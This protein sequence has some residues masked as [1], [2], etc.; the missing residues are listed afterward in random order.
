MPPPL[1]LSLLAANGQPHPKGEPLDRT[2]LWIAM[3]RLRA[4]PPVALLLLLTLLTGLLSVRQARAQ[5]GVA[6]AGEPQGQPPAVR[7]LSIR[8]RS[9]VVGASG[10]LSFEP[11]PSGGLVRLTAL[12]LPSLRMLFPGA[13]GYFVW[14]VP[15]KGAPIRVGELQIDASG[16][17]GVEFPR[18]EP[19]ERYSVIVTAELSKAAEKPKGMV[20]FSTW[21]GEAKAFFGPRNKTPAN[22]NRAFKEIRKRGQLRSAGSDFFAEVDEAL[23]LSLGRGRVIELFG[24]D[25]SPEAYGVA[26]VTALNSKAYIRAGFTKLPPPQ[27]IGANTYVLWAIKQSGQ[28]RYMGSLPT[29]EELDDSD[30]FVRVGGFNTNDY[31][32]FVTAE[33]LR[34]ASSPTGPRA[35]SSGQ[36]VTEPN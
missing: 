5:S 6:T 7:P 35:L 26:R 19:L 34:P 29:V 31:D 23:N 16:N 32:L 24:Q 27:M 11:T 1:V 18:P 9:F 15:S 21:L 20:I 36:G 22:S 3:T 12:G 25:A 14:A 4:V 30:I 2:S 17:G 28:I 13:Q 33:K 10:A 8:L